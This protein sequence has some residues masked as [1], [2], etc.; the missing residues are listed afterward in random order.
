MCCVSMS[1]TNT[2]PADDEAQGDSRETQDAIES[3]DEH[4]PRHVQTCV[5]VKHLHRTVSK[6]ESQ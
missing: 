4:E 5:G 1:T 2:R 6:F 3:C